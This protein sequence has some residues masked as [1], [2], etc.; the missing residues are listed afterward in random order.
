[1]APSAAVI[2]RP[3]MLLAVKPVHCPPPDGRCIRKYDHL[4]AR[5]WASSRSAEEP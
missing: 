2:M 3:P 5:L 1:M 4:T